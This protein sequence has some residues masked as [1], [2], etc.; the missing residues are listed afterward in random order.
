MPFSPT[1]IELLAL[2][3]CIAFPEIAGQVGL[4]EQDFA[5]PDRRAFFSALLTTRRFLPNGRPALTDV[6]ERAGLAEAWILATFRV[7]VTLREQA[8]E[9]ARALRETAIGERFRVE[10]RSLQGKH[11]GME[12]IRETQ[13]AAQRAALLGASGDDVIS[14]R[15]AAMRY[16]D[17]QEQR[18]TDLRP[19]GVSCGL[20]TVDRALKGLRGGELTVLVGPGSSGKST[21][22]S[23]FA[24]EVA[25]AGHHV[26][27]FSGEMTHE[28]SGERVTYAEACIP[29]SENL[30]SL[31]R[32]LA[33]AARMRQASELDRI[34]IDHRS[35]FT[36]ARTRSVTESIK[37]AR[38]G[39]ALVIFD[40]LRH[41]ES[42][43]GREDYL[44]LAAGAQEAKNFATD[45]GAHVIVLAHMNAQASNEA[46]TAKDGGRPHLGMLRGGPLIHDVC[47]NMLCLWSPNGLASLF[48][49][50][51]RQGGKSWQGK[52]LRL[53]YDVTTQTYAEFRG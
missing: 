41:I 17:A 13:N 19:A 48:F 53:D 33:A 51:C 5:D 40:H 4:E 15:E 30:A 9:Y 22:A 28:Q 20:P 11:S 42:D 44:R 38:G 24:L 12:L 1:D 47:D 43:G 36:R 26:V 31:E 2:R 16:V 8:R 49:W 32:L 23:G 21:V 29:L 39:V 45:T 50:K 35:S 7:P 46:G 14:L 6:A 10:L 18:R 3:S 25:R 27:V 37:N 34:L 52:E